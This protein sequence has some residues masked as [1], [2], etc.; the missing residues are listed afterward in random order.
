M[1]RMLS[2]LFFTALGLLAVLYAGTVI[3]VFVFILSCVIVTALGITGFLCKSAELRKK[4]P[5]LICLGLGLFLGSILSQ[6]ITGERYSFFTGTDPSRVAWFKGY[7]TA[8]DQKLHDDVSVC[9]LQLTAAATKDRSFTA[10]AYGEIRLFIRH[11]TGV[12]AGQVIEVRGR[13]TGGQKNSAGTVSSWVDNKQIHIVGFHSWF[14]HARY[15][16]LQWCSARIEK[17]G[18][19][20][21]S[22]FKALF[23]GDRRG[24]DADLRQSL[25]NTG[26]VHLLAVSGLHVGIVFSFIALLLFPL[27]S[28]K[29]K[30]IVGSLFV[31]GYL[32]LVGAKPS[33]LRASIMI[34]TAGI[35]SLLD[36]DFNPLNIFYLSL[37]IAV[38]IDPSSVF[39]LS[40]GLSYCAV[41]G[42]LTVGR[43]LN[44]FLI[45][46]LPAFVRVPLSFSLGAQCA[47]LPLVLIYFK[48]VYVLSFLAALIMVPLVTVFV[49]GGIIFLAVSSIPFTPVYRSAT[50]IFEFLYRAIFRISRFFSQI[51]VLITEWN[52]W[53]LAV[54]FLL[55]GMAFYIFY[56]RKHYEL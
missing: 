53:Y 38:C 48:Q 56:R 26:S 16:V 32:F 21:N 24:L 42:I 9:T 50:V 54:F 45:P 10:E 1:T 36:R 19:P 13:L 17:M 18:A 47:T 12:Y 3:P 33:L 7:L 30:I 55:G 25:V 6:S 5:A 34:V 11:S 41:F 4:G 15:A 46:Y 44:S 40:F 28:K 39:T 14:S 20:Q 31:L 2:P 37:V 52:N 49:W 35:A 29:I 22:L 8:D 27:P 23:L 51:P 43:G